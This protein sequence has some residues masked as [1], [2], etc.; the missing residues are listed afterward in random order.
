MRWQRMAC[1]DWLTDRLRRTKRYLFSHLTGGPKRFL[2]SGR[3]LP[4]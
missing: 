4:E 1:C 3:V 2:L